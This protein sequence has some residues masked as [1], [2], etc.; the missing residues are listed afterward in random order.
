MRYII[1]WIGFWICIAFL[2]ICI[3]ILDFS[4]SHEL[5]VIGL[6]I[7]A[8]ALMLAMGGTLV[9]GIYAFFTWKD[10]P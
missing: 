8:V 3:E 7:E 10:F 9:G 1:G 2:G 4:H 6:N 5:T